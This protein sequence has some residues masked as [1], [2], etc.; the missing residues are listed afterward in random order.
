[1]SAI[2]DIPASWYVRV[3]VAIARMLR[4]SETLRI[5]VWAVRDRTVLG[6]LSKLHLKAIHRIRSIALSRANLEALSK[7]HEHL[8]ELAT[9]CRDVMADVIEAWPDSVHCTIK[10]CDRRKAK[11]KGQV[12]VYTIARSRGSDTRPRQFGTEHAHLV[13]ENSAFAALVGC[14]DRKNVW[15]PRVFKCFACNDLRDHGNYDCSRTDWDAYWRSTCVFP[16]RFRA[17]DGDHHVFGFLTFDSPKPGAFRGLPNIYDYHNNAHS[18]KKGN[19]EFDRLLEYRSA[20]H[21]GG[22]LADTLSTMF[23]PMLQEE[24]QVQ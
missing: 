4:K 13:G 15:G 23:L 22:I 24:R 1:M 17:P 3:A 10:L 20:F 8:E 7:S 18:K 19:D 2:S 11:N 9:D 6:P 12:K 16:L 5:I 14:N 21:I